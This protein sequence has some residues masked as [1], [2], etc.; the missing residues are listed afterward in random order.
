LHITDLWGTVP[1]RSVMNANIMGYYGRCPQ[2]GGA[3]GWVGPTG[4]WRCSQC[5]AY[6]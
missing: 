2:C 5:G 3:L 1:P 4:R 6:W